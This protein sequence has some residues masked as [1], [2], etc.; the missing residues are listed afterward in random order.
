MIT[1]EL[2]FDWSPDDMVEV[3][4]LTDGSFLTVRETLSRIGI[5]SKANKSLTQTAH[6]LHKRGRYYIVHFKEL[7]AL[8]GRSTTM[9][10][11]DAQRRNCIAT[12]LEQWGLVKIVDPAIRATDDI[13]R[14][15]LSRL[16]VLSY[17]EKEQWNIIVKYKIGG[18][19]T[20]N[21]EAK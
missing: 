9:T 21:H 7:F 14:R 19:K 16:T 17:E 5:A 15:E 10:V 18:D 3:K 8:D 11:G 12:L 1:T 20:R 13:M 2:L 4:L 6:I